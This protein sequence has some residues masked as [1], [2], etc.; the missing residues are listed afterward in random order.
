[1]RKVPA[2]ANHRENVVV[3]AKAVARIRVHDLWHFE[4]RT[5]YTAAN[6]KQFELLAELFERAFNL[7]LQPL[8][9]GSLALRLLEPDGRRRDYEDFKPTRFVI[10][11]DGESQFPDYPWTLK[12]PEPKDF[13]GN[14]LVHLRR[15][16]IP[17]GRDRNVLC[18]A[19]AELLAAGGC[20][21][22][23]RCRARR[24]G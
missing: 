14:D 6:P 10:G 24:R 16:V 9:A 21:R 18:R 13:L 8:T 22:I 15:R 11:P 2:A 5:L 12:G 1:M 7:S 23:R 20:R 4:H 19:R 3:K 17:D